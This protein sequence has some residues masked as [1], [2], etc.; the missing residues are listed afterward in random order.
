V[1]SYLCASGRYT[2]RYVF[3]SDRRPRTLEVLLA[4][5]RSV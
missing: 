3:E 5:V 4:P 1:P 2:V